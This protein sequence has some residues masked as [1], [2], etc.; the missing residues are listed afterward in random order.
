MLHHEETR[1]LHELVI[2]KLD[3]WYEGKDMFDVVVGLETRG[4]FLGLVISQHYKIPFVPIRKKGR[5]FYFE[6]FT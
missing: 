5:Q 1:L 6:I 4:F 3:N 2:E